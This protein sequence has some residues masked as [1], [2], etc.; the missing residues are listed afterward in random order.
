M[1]LLVK[2]GDGGTTPVKE[3][4]YMQSRQAGA[5]ADCIGRLIPQEGVDYDMVVIFNGEADDNVQMRITPLTDKGEW[6]RGY[7]AEMIKKYPPNVE[8]PDMSIPEDGEDASSQDKP[9]VI[10]AEVVS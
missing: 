6:W 9:E 1:K 10:D 3:M 2:S 7:V 8:N 5:I 4:S